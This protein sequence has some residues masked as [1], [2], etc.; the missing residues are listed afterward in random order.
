MAG[1]GE[2]GRG[3]V[4]A[5]ETACSTAA[6]DDAPSLVCKAGAGG[7]CAR[8]H[9]LSNAV[10]PFSEAMFGLAGSATSPSFL[11]FF[12]SMNRSMSVRCALD[13]MAPR[14]SQVYPNSNNSVTVARSFFSTASNNGVWRLSVTQLILAVLLSK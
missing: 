6:A 12:S 7:M 2:D 3:T 13:S 11:A 4:P 1:S 14:A 8:R 5:T 9:R 10:H